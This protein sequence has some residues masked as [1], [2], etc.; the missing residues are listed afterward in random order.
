MTP[1]SWIFFGRA[2]KSGALLSFEVPP[3]GVAEEPFSVWSPQPVRIR[4]P[5]TAIAPTAAIRDR[6]A[7]VRRVVLAVMSWF[8]RQAGGASEN[9]SCTHLRVSRPRVITASCHSD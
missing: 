8:L 6:A 3:E 1:A 4:A 9:G 2:E 7:V 5:A